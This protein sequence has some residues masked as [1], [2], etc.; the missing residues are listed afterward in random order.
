MID[1]LHR[2]ALWIA[3]SLLRIVWRLRRTTGHG[4]FVAVWSGERLLL[5]HNSYRAGE[6]LPCGAVARGETPREAACRELR[7]E[8]GIEIAEGA[9]RFAC[10]LELDLPIKRDIASIFELEVDDLPELRIDRREVVWAGFCPRDELDTR[11]LVR[12]VREYLSRAHPPA[13][14]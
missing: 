1:R 4:A 14:R 3:Y 7:E 6:T 13:A 2:L 11:P 9:L 12:H 10:Q 8:V 5:I